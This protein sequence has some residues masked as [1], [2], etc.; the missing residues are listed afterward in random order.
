MQPSPA[1][2][3]IGL[4]LIVAG[5]AAAM[6]LLA[7][8]DEAAVVAIKPVRVEAP[9]VQPLFVPE[10]PRGPASEALT[11]PPPVPAPAVV[12]TRA[13]PAKPAAIDFKL[14]G[15]STEGSE[16]ALLLYGGGRTLRVRGTGPID[17]EYA[18][19]AIRDGLLVLRFVPSG[20]T[21]VLEI[22]SRRREAAPDWSAA[23][24]PPD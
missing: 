10:P 3:R 1:G 23:D 17:D 22:A 9:F 7:W 5:I 21:Q 4:A 19:D 18:V 15:T 12:A 13:A 20:S 16:T 8:P 2:G 6:A 14:L 24:S 11:L